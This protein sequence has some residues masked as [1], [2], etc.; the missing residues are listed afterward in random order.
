[1]MGGKAPRQKAKRNELALVQLLKAV[2]LSAQRVPNSGCSGGAFG[3]DIQITI[4]GCE[5]SVRIEAKCRKDGFREDY[6]WL[7]GVDALIKGSMTNGD[8]ALIVLRLK[9]VLAAGE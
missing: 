8:D 4:P 5:G 2:G 3:A 1:M 9:D 7:E 6:K